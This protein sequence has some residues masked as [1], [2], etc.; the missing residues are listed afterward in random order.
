MMDGRVKAIKDMLKDIGATNRVAVMSYSVKFASKFYGPFRDA[1]H[2]APSFGD[3]KRYQLPVG[4]RGLAMRAADRDV[5][6]GAD[7][8]MVK[9]GLAYLDV[10][11]E[12]KLRHPELPMAIYQV[13]GQ[14]SSLRNPADICT[15]TVLSSLSGLWGVRHV[16][17]RRS[18]GCLRPSRHPR[19]N[20]DLD[21][22]KWRRYC[23]LL[24]HAPVTPVGPRGSGEID[25]LILST[26]YVVLSHE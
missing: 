16:V 5:V 11:R 15:I 9:P 26:I 3:R 12:V 7:M 14:V 2:S 8:L 18:R 6:E 13:A 4:G 24:L 19:R 1:A 17:S 20:P 25:C 10:V 22:A 23:N 21:E